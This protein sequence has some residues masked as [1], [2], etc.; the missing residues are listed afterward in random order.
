M[1]GSNDRAYWNA[2][3]MLYL[4]ICKVNQNAYLRSNRF[5]LA[6]THSLKVQTLI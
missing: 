5:L 4:F 6:I 2:E 3:E 1:K